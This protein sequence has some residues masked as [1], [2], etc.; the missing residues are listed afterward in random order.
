MLR[1]T[2]KEYNERSIFKCNNLVI[3]IRGLTIDSSCED[4][5]VYFSICDNNNFNNN[6]TTWL[7]AEDSLKLS[8]MLLES[9][10]TK[11]PM[12]FKFSNIL[13]SENC[14]EFDPITCDLTITVNATRIVVCLS[15]IIT[16]FIVAL[17]NH[18]TFAFLC[19]MVNHQKIHCY[20]H[21]SRW[22]HEDRVERIDVIEK[23]EYKDKQVPGYGDGYRVVDVKPIWKPGKAP[24]HN[25][26]F[27]LEDIVCFPVSED[28]YEFFIKRFNNGMDV[29]VTFTPTLKE[30]REKFLENF[31]Q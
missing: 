20:G 27:S 4:R 28:E 11:E 29:E 13:K 2:I 15:D 22:I 14:I 9:T 8:S 3:T 23:N 1:T 16:D 24:K 5:D 12:L 7:V 19:N 10:K 6:I 26:D 31:R 21:L 18:S 30:V 17:I 25:E